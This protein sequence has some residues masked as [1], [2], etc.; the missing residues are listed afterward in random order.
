MFIFI[1]NIPGKKY[2]LTTKS[3]YYLPQSRNLQR[4]RISRRRLF[5]CQ[6]ARYDASKSNEV[7]CSEVV[8]H[9]LADFLLLHLC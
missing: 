8:E 6:A 5:Q 4:T 1:K 9:I 2:K 7:F 3:L